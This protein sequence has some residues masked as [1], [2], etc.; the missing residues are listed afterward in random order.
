MRDLSKEPPAALLDLLGRLGLADA[1]QVRAQYRHAR[2]L[3]GD[4]PLFESVWIDALVRARILTPYQA[5]VLLRDDTNRS[6]SLAV[7]PF[8]LAGSLVS[9]GYADYYTARETKTGRCVRLAVARPGPHRAEDL[10]VRLSQ[11]A[12]KSKRVNSPCFA[13]IT[14]SGVAD[15][16]IWAA[17]PHVDGLT[18]VEWMTGN[19]RF[20]PQATLEIARQMAAALAVL[21]K[22]GLCHGDLAAWNLILTQS[23]QVILP[24][25]GIRGAFRPEE[26]Y[27]QADLQPEGYDYLAPERITQGTPPTVAS[28]IFACGCV[29]W[30]LLT[31][32]S[33]RS[34]GTALAKLRAAQEAEIPDVMLLAPE[35]PATLA[36]AISACAEPRLDRR[37]ESMAK[38][39]AML[40]PP[41]HA[42]R[43]HVGRCISR[44]GE[45]P[46]PWTVSLSAARHS[47]HTPVWL[48]A[49]AGCVV[50]AAALMWIMRPT[51]R[52]SRLANRESSSASAQPAPAKPVPPAATDGLDVATLD[53]QPSTLNSVP[54]VAAGGLDAR[55]VLDA[56][57]ERG[58]SLVLRTGQI[59]CG[60]PNQRPTVLVPPRGLVVEPEG[61]R[62]ENI[63]FVW[64]APRESPS[65]DDAAQR[66]AMVELRASGAEFRGCSFQSQEQDG[67]STVGCPA[68]PVAI[69]WVHPVDRSQAR[70]SLPSGR[71]ALVDCVIRGARAGVEC[72]TAGAVAVELTNVL[73]LGAGPLVALDHCPAA[74]EPVAV[75]MSN[76][77][78]RGPGAALECRYQEMVQPPGRIRIQAD[79]CAFV[80]GT[81]SGLLRFA[82]PTDP[83]ALLTQIE[84]TGDGSLVSPEAAVADWRQPDGRVVVLDDSTVSIAGLVR[85]KA[86]FAGPPDVGPAA[87]R[88]TR[89]QAPLRSPDPP[90]VNPQSLRWRQ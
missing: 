32:R 34:G 9:P 14:Q 6:E 3:A 49:I 78:L 37:P 26:S 77:T 67:Q 47:N 83:M 12:S 5:G 75:A 74:D 4:L 10:L 13:P 73:Y 11:L 82:G 36:A 45:Q 60:R 40:G 33:P 43:L 41:T 89:W 50:A 85:S 20:P 79:Q 29:W 86:E 62:F 25:P 55:L 2:R 23:G 58:N 66:A 57:P 88:I 42:G 24:H 30:H 7:G 19:G 59:V 53:V 22:A 35:T 72:R 68:A 70:L 46:S 51:E 76:V 16:R 8:V 54:P 52:D 61:V 15:D 31:G 1:A 90:G 81:T 27:A 18:A 21:E 44:P 87:S 64:Q 28:D 17:S 63:D 84:W 71:V 56:G 80:G 69:R 65:G 38:L 39:A 48:A